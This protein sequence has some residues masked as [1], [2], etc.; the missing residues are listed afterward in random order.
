LG[1]FFEDA[2]SQAVTEGVSQPET[3]N[4]GANQMIEENPSFL[5]LSDDDFMLLLC[6]RA[7]KL[8]EPSR[9]CRQMRAYAQASIDGPKTSAEAD[10]L[11]A[12]ME[13]LRDEANGEW[14]PNGD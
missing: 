6:V 13:R 5:N 9:W 14:S 1:K 3:I 8:A 11:L 12:M 4:R 2:A 7:E 10:E